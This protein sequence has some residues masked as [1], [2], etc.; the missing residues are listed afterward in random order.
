MKE[1]VREMYIFTTQL[2]SIKKIEEETKLVISLEEKKLLNEAITSLKNQLRI[3]N[4]S[5]TE[6]LKNVSFYKKIPESKEIKE[7][8]I[9]Q[10]NYTP[11]YS[12]ER[13]SLVI[14][15]K[16]R[17]DFLENL[18]RSN[19]TINKLKKE[20]SVKKEL[21]TFG[22][23]NLY[24]KISNKFFRETSNK[25]ISKGYFLKLNK[26]LR[27]INS[28]FILNTYVSMILFSVLLSFIFSIF[29]L[30]FL[31]F[32]DV[33]LVYPFIKFLPN[34]EKNFLRLIKHVWLIIIIPFLT[35]LL[36]YFYPASQRKNLG[37]KIDRE[38]PFL[39]I[40]M[41]AIAN[42][43]IEPSNIFK[44]ILNSSDYPYSNIEF[45]KIINLI[46]FHGKD[47]VSALKDTAHSSP[48]KKLK[49]FLESFATT[50]TSG[51]DL[52]NFLAKH[53]ENMLFDY[54]IE[55]EKYIKVSEIFMNIYIS[56]V[57]A[58]PT[59]LLTLLIILES[60]GATTSFLGLTSEILNLLIILIIVLLN[61]IFLA[62]LK[63]KQ[64]VI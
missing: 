26:E 50:I 44:I 27:K 8:K 56:I 62:F 2:N 29:I 14:T 63:I 13:V 47:L 6:L 17:E 32:F 36:M 64:P 51:G 48:S 37:S 39:T 25:L 61:L 22:K 24:A 1:I 23:P 52:R 33:S 59:I 5:I 11:L 16:D 10:I 21:P 19:L 38:L 34:E 20:Y 49:E 41:S 35:G 15:D 46:N 4:N 53:S 57:V 40:H 54:K 55:M 30:V 42:S 7:E 43:G 28:P 45:R 9:I 18:R 12:D 60:T 3:I 31:I 58:A